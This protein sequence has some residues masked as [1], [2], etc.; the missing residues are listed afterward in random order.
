MKSLDEIRDEKITIAHKEVDSKIFTKGVEMGWN[1]CQ[2]EMEK[3]IAPLV[4]ALKFYADT[5]RYDPYDRIVGVEITARE[6]LKQWKEA[7]K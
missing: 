5:N 4:V 3:R 7:I 1:E 6:A 2:K